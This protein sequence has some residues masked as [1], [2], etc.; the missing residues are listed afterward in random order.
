MGGKRRGMMRE[1]SKRGRRRGKWRE[2]SAH[3][4]IS[5]LPP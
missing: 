1:K 5:D 2:K 3:P 4:E